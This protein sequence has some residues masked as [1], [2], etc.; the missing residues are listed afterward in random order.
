MRWGTDYRSKPLV[1]ETC[2]EIVSRDLDM[3]RSICTML[4][5]DVRYKGMWFSL[6]GGTSYRGEGEDLAPYEGMG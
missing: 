1:N 6:R 2:F 3:R 5:R 4:R